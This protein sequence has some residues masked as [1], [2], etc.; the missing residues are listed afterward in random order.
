MLECSTLAMNDTCPKIIS[1]AGR[2]PGLDQLT[3]RH[4]MQLIIV[5]FRA[6][7]SLPTI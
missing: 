7:L 6:S 1:L 2:G 5:N 3:N 4:D